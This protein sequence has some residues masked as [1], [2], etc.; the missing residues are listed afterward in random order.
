MHPP[1][2][3]IAILGGGMAS[4]SAAFALTHSPALRE[5]YEITVYQD[6]WLLGGKGASVRN[7]EAHGRI[8]EHGLHV[9]LGYYENAFTL[10]RRCYEELGRPPG[11]A[12]RTLRD[13]F[14]KH[15]AI[16]VGEQTARGW[17]HWSVSFPETDEWPGEGRPLPSIT[18]SIRA[19]ALQ[20]LRYA[21][22]WWKQRQGV[23]PEFDGVAQQLRGLL[24]RMLSPRSSQPGGIP[25]R[26]LADGLSSLLDRLR[27]LARGDFEADAHLRRMWIVLEFGAITV[28]GIL[29]DG[30]HGPSANFEALD[31]V[32]YCDWLRK[33]GASERMVSSG[34]IRAFYHLAFCDGAGAGAGLAILGMLRMFTCYRGAIFYKMR[35][36][37]GE[38][39]FAPLYEVLRRRGVRFEFFHR[40]QRLELSTDQARIE[41]VVIGRQATP[42]SGEY[43]PLIDVGGLPCWPEQPLYNQLVEGEALARHGAA[44]ASFWS[45]WPPVE[46]RTLH[47]GT[48]F[49]RVLL[50]ISAGA[51]PFIASE[52]IAAS[53]RWQHMVK[54]VQTVRTV[55]LQLWVNAPIGPLA[56]SVDAPVTTAYQVPLETW[57]DM[58]HLIPIEGWKKSS[59]V[60]GI[61]YACGQLGHGS[62]P[63][64]ESDPRAYDRAALEE[65]ARRFLQEHLSHIWPGGADARGGL[66]WERLFDPQ[67]RTGPERLRAQYLRVN[68]DPSDRY[69]LSVPGS[70]KHRIAPDASGF[71][72]LVL[73]G[74][75]TRTGYDLG[76]IEAA[77]MSGL[78]AA[79]ALG[80]PVS[81]IGEV[82]R[83]HIEPRIT[84]PRYVDRPGEMSLRSPYVME[85]VWM[86][87]LVLQAQQASLGALLD[88]YLNAPARGHVRYVPAAPFVV[89]A[90][91][92]SGR[93][94][95]GD[96][97][98]RRLGYM[99]ETDVAFWVPA[100]AMRS[101]KGGLIPERL[102]W[103][104]PHVFVST[105]AAAAA[106]RE[107]YGFPKSVVGVQMSRSGQALDHLSVEGE[108]LAQH[109]P[110]TCGTR[111]RI[112]EVTRREGGTGAPSSIAELLGGITR[113]LDA[114]GAWASSLAN[115]FAVSEVT[116]AFL[117]QFRDVQ[118]T[119]RA[120]YQAI[121]EAKAT[122]R[123]LRGQGPIPGTFHVSWGDYASHP[124]AADLGLQ[125]GGQQALAAIWAD[126]DFVME[127]GREIFRA[128]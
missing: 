127:S 26:E 73:A 82:P 40:V 97:E 76:C 69:V 30:L 72:N 84:L 54:N 24:K 68:A 101:G 39:V 44:L 3:K 125:P 85:D 100:W 98:H 93:S 4:L 62:D 75:W 121:I 23:R 87:A 122:V 27:A 124:F 60:Q 35:A 114:S 5:R 94:F 50:G 91:A 65:T 118:H 110:E 112:L 123:T 119:E 15:G 95:S 37:M 70:Q 107:I 53:P 45:Q 109:T 56:T 31:E 29:R 113:P 59:G 120:C 89:L 1:V 80:A 46:Q 88:K 28:I 18:E 36:G 48:D 64:S 96:P 128:S 103:F 21:L 49:H 86:T 55:S 66:Q 104:L 12:M 42:R 83:R 20:V 108:V 102:V 117:K 43:Q 22:V 34:L 57:A 78:M 90:A 14:I 11:A 2:E 105:G 7:R 38:T 63:V 111:A 8:E 9:W 67:G 25:A 92:F 41:R 52:L 13:A 47:L 74:D 115:K 51:L 6:G 61:L 58:S 106:G 99:P 33:H 71:E 16:A 17:E 19:A 81:I 10:L 116:I 79:R 32:E 126:F 77:V